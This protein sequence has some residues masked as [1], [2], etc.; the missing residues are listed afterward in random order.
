[1]ELGL[2][3]K[4]C[5]VTGGCNGIGAEITKAFLREGAE[6]VATTRRTEGF[7]KHNWEKVPRKL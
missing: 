1:M 2:H 4:R 6:V 3:Q 5:L 7:Y